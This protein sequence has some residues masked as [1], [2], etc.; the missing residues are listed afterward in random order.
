[1]DATLDAGLR[2][3][4]RQLVDK[5]GLLVGKVDDLEFD[6][7]DDR[8]RPPQLTAILAGPGALAGRL[9]GPAGRWLAAI[10]SRLRDAGQDGPA[11]VPW[12]AVDDLGSAVH[13]RVG[14]EALKT[15]VGEDWVR[16]HVIGRLPGA[17]DATE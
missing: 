8:F 5:D 2:L 13:L 11:R 16:D 9:G 4:D 3:L 14:R 15:D 10:S 12:G 6:D 1:M 7:T 17:G